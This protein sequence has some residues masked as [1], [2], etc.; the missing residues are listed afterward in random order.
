MTV[1]C[2]KSPGVRIA[3]IAGCRSVL[4]SEASANT[5][6]PPVIALLREFAPG[7]GVEIDIAKGIPVGG[8][9]GSSAASAVAAV[10]AADA[11][12]GTALPRERLLELAIEGER[13]ASGAVHVDNL[14]PSLW[15]G[16]VLVRGY[17]PIDIV[18][19]RVPD[20][21]WC[22]VISPEIEVRTDHARSILPREIPLPDVIT[23]TGNAAG[24][25]AG[26][27]TGD[28][29]LVGRSLHDAIAEPARL[30]LIPGFA[31]MKE[32]ALGRG[33]LGCGISGSG[34]SLFALAAS[35]EAARSIAGAMGE[36]LGK[37]GFR[38]STLVSRVGAP[39]A[40]V[41]S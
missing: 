39:G 13:I 25:V 22:C 16:F 29:A 6:G 8:G 35:R 40:G 32:A 5:A 9:I 17:H 28:L 37:I 10:V 20:S 21:L 19:I 27:Y 34:P 36:V 1:R 31:Q 7:A 18:S 41:I 24:L 33:A 11:L 15:G 23:Q 2:T 3:G 38:F 30:H 12:L 4:P 14:A 26:L